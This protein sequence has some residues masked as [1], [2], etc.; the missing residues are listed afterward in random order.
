MPAE[1]QD[2]ERLRAVAEHQPPFGKY[3]GLRITNATPELLEAQF[4]VREDMTNRNG[5]LHGGVMSAICDNMGG[6]ATFMTMAADLTTTTIEAKT[7][8]FRSMALGETGTA[9][10]TF[11]HKGRRT[12][13]LQTT[14]YRPDG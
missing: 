9:Q 6:S 10:T 12:A 4:T 2:H 8:F 3:L 5:V 11:L 13:V 7:N 14:L 1:Q